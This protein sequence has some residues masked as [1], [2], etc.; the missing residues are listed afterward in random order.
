MLSLLLAASNDSC[1]CLSSVDEK[2]YLQTY[3]DHSCFI[4]VLYAFDAVVA[5]NFDAVDVLY[6]STFYLLTFTYL[7]YI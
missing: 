4:V 5:V 1:L 2:T 7:I 3:I 6:K